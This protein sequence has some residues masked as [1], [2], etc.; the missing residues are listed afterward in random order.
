MN[1]SGQYWL[2]VTFI[3]TNPKIEKSYFL[4]FELSF[5]CHRSI[6]QFEF[7]FCFPFFF[8][9]KLHSLIM[10]IA[11]FLWYYQQQEDAEGAVVT[12]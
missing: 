10:I 3:Y 12:K 2:D 6:A 9:I 8:N 7:C 5:H 1:T 4:K 11:D